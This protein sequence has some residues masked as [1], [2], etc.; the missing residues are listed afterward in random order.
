MH[1]T[2]SLRQIPS[3]PYREP[4]WNNNNNNYNNNNSNNNN[5]HNN[6]NNHKNNNNNNNNILNEIPLYNNPNLLLITKLNIK[7]YLQ[8]ISFKKLFSQ[9]NIFDLKKQERHL[10]SIEKIHFIKNIAYIGKKNSIK[11]LFISTKLGVIGA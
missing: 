8:L 3:G 9:S 11:R 4:L 7:S 1:L 6:H 5:N 2:Q 10:I